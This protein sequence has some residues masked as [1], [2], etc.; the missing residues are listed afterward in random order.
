MASQH[1]YDS[2]INSIK[3]SFTIH[4]RKDVKLNT[5]KPHPSKN[6]ITGRGIG[7]SFKCRFK[8]AAKKHVVSE[9]Q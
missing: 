4:T 9:R 1:L 6:N 5:S 7:K 8:N 2:Q 3:Y